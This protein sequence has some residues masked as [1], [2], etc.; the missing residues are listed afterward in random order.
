M[1]TVVAKLPIREGKL[2]E[3]LSAFK[4]LI[5]EVAKE[6]G[7]KLYSLNR[8]PKTPN[9]LV[10]V[11]QYTDKAALDFHSGT[12]HFKAFFAASAALLGG[13]P[14]ITVLEEIASI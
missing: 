3:A 8:D 2:D 14:E 7:T 1:L 11:E 4:T 5:A 10:V 6:E 9:L 12:P 13:K